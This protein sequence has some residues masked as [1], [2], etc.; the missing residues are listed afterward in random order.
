MN[1]RQ[2]QEEALNAVD[3]Y[4]C[5]CTVAI[6]GTNP[7]VPHGSG[8]AVMYNGVYYVLSAAHVLMGEPDDNKIRLVGRPDGPLQLVKGKQRLAAA[9]ARGTDAQV[10]SSATAISIA[11]RL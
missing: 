8:V 5:S 6:A 10:F 1:Q 9:V 4:T 11:G 3:E 7:E 2:I